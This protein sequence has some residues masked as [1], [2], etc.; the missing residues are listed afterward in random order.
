MRQ[1]SDSSETGK[2]RCSEAI[3]SYTVVAGNLSICA[4]L[5]HQIAQHNV[6]IAQIEKTGVTAILSLW[7]VSERCWNRRLAGERSCG[8]VYVIMLCML[9][10]LPR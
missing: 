5:H 7:H 3:Q 4:I 10:L 1:S 9:N 8:L 6:E 2:P